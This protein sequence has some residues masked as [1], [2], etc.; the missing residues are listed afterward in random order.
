MAGK[1]VHLA[2]LAVAACV[3]AAPLAH[4]ETVILKS[5][6]KAANEVPPNASAA[7]GAAEASLDTATR[8]LTWKVTYSGLTGPAMGAHFHGPSEPG[9]NAGI[10]LPFKSP[11]SPISGSAVITDAQAADLLAGKWYANVHTQANPGGEIRGQMT[12]Q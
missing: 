7:S 12:R 6:L 5:E 8:T 2:L 1:F 3:A 4:A 10:V 9:K 11:E